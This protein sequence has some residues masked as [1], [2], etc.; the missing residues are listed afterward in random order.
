M[1]KRILVCPGHGGKDAGSVGNGLQE[2]Q[3]TWQICTQ[4]RDILNNTFDCEA[5]LIQPSM[6]NHNVDFMQDLYGTINEANKIHS[7][8]P[9]DFYLSIHINSATIETAEGFESFCYPASQGKEVDKIRETIHN[10]V[11]KLLKQYNIY[12][13]G[14]RYANFAELRETKMKS[15]LFENLFIKN[16]KDANLLGDPVFISK[17]A[18]EYAYGLSLALN[19]IRK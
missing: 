5:I 7:K 9:V 1:T 17:L 16:K 18:N 3:L 19:L 13:R 15:A 11:M 6:T 12:D 14:K 8:T 2:K 4:I 10:Q